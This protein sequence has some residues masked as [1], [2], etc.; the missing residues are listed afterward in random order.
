MKSVPNWIH[1]IGICGV[2]TSGLAVMFKYEGSKVTGSD[3]GFFPPVS[4]FLDKYDI[5][6]GIG[7]KENRLTDE[8]GNHPEFCL[9]YTS[10]CV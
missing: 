6:I 5:P 9:L 4:N 10:R 1:I 2:V 3:K 8:D 7:Y